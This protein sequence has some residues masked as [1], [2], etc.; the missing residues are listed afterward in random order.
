MAD[1]NDDRRNGMISYFQSKVNNVEDYITKVSDRLKDDPSRTLEW[2]TTA[3]RAAA[4]LEVYQKIVSALTGKT[5]ATLESV[6]DYALKEVLRRASNPSHSAS[7]TGDLLD[8][9]VLAAWARAYEFMA[10]VLEEEKREAGE[11]T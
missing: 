9:E 8:Q 2:G 4:E 10:A 3:F 1:N 7:T 6:C 5:K 11:A